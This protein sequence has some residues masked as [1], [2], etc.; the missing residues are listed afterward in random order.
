MSENEHEDEMSEET[1]EES[2]ED[3][4]E[5][6]APAPARELTDDDGAQL[7]ELDEKL[8]GFESAKRW[9]D[10]IKTLLAKA[11]IHTD[12]EEKA[13]LFRQAGT[14]YIERSSNQAEAIECFEQLIEILPNDVEAIT[15]LKEMYEKRRNWESLIGIMEREAQM[16]DPA[17]RPL[18]YAEIAEPATKPIPKPDGRIGLAE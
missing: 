4:G 8:A 2:M 5:T 15:R 18:R 3:A 9:S 14:M 6:E 10:V 1:P 12:P 17:D 7:A 11:D 13:E 16:L